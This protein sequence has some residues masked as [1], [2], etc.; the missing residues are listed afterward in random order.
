MGEWVRGRGWAFF[1]LYGFLH[2]EVIL[3]SLQVFFLFISVI[4]GMFTHVTIRRPPFCR[5]DRKCLSGIGKTVGEGGGKSSTFLFTFTICC[6]CWVLFCYITVF[7]VCEFYLTAIPQAIV[8]GINNCFSV[9]NCTFS[10]FFKFFF[11]SLFWHDLHRVRG[12]Q[13]H[14]AGFWAGWQPAVHSH[15]PIRHLPLHKHR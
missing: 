4:N 15:I 5:V 2:Y 10:W 6:I 11:S 1:C 7:L 3:T 9:T 13:L 8:W 12:N 14:H